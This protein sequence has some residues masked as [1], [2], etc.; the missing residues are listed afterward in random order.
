[1]IAALYARK[2]TDDSARNTEARSTQRQIDSAKAYAKAKGWT[3]DDRFVI[4]QTRTP[5]ASGAAATAAPLEPRDQGGALEEDLVALIVANRNRPAAELVE[6][7][8]RVDEP[9]QIRVAPHLAIGDH[10]GSPAR[11]Q[12][13]GVVDGAVL[14][15]LELD[16]ADRARHVRVYASGRRGAAAFDDL[17]AVSGR[18]SVS[19]RDRA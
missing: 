11:L 1:M 19:G 3:V 13:H 6:A 14:G 18:H 10:R 16:V 2:S 5:A 15:A 4:C 7:V 17:G 12:A 8:D 9:A